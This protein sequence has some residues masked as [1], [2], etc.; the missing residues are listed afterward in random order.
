MAYASWIRQLWQNL[1]TIQLPLVQN[2]RICPPGTEGTYSQTALFSVSRM[3]HISLTLSFLIQWHGTLHAFVIKKKKKGKLKKP[4]EH[5]TQSFFLHWE[6]SMRTSKPYLSDMTHCFEVVEKAKL[7]TLH[8][9][10]KKCKGWAR[11][12]MSL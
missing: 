6:D 4:K 10:L 7:N 3:R 12:Y 2:Y 8:F 9:A 1:L 5:V 11:M